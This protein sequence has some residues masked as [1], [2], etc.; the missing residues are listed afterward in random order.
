M[1]DK[2]K[3]I[4]VCIALVLIVLAA[5]IAVALTTMHWKDLAIKNNAAE[6]YLDSNYKRQFRWIK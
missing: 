2:E 4:G 6:Y 5:T 1:R 3:D